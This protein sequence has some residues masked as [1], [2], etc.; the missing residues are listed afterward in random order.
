[1]PH[2]TGKFPRLLGIIMLVTSLLAGVFYLKHID[3]SGTLVATSAPASGSLPTVGTMAGSPMSDILTRQQTVTFAPMALSPAMGQIRLDI[4]I[5]QIGPIQKDGGFGKQTYTL[6]SLPNHKTVWEKTHNQLITLPSSTKD[7]NQTLGIK[8]RTVTAGETT[9]PENASYVLTAALEQWLL[10]SPNLSLAL[11][12]RTGTVKANP[13][14][15]AIIFA[16]LFL[17]VFLLYLTTSPEQR[18]QAK[19]KKRK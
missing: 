3:D 18:A 9:V 10:A 4:K 12:A 1:M 17:S 8:S 19:A 11:E 14:Y 5:T 7:N 15:I 16:T 6:A 13:V 2:L